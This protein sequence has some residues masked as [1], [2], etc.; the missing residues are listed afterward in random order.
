MPRV[1]P[2]APCHRAHSLGEAKFSFLTACQNIVFSSWLYLTSHLSVIRVHNRINGLR[3]VHWSIF[4]P[5][6]E[7]R[8]LWWVFHCSPPGMLCEQTETQLEGRWSQVTLHF[9]TSSVGGGG[10]KKGAPSAHGRGVC[11]C[12]C[13]M[14]VCCARMHVSVLWVCVSVCAGVVV[15][16]QPQGLGRYNRRR[17]LGL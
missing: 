10:V 17:K 12:A 2:K 14:C 3:S 13:W 16:V 9:N 11:T 5:S 4:H 6:P 7:E 1:R 15:L 8:I